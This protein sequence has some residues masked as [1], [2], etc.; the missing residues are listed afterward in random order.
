MRQFLKAVAGTL[1]Q[2]RRLARDGKAAA[3]VEFAGLLPFML[4]LYVGGV[5]VALGVSADRKVTLTSRTVADLASRQTNI[6]DP[7]MTN[8]LGASSAV[9]APFDATKV[10]VIVSN[11]YINNQGVAHVCWSNALNT[12][13][14]TVGS[15]VTLPA[16]LVNK[17]TALMW[18]EASYAYAPT[19]GYYMTG[20]MTLYDNIYM[21]PRMSSTVTRNSA[22]GSC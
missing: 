4:L 11:V 21:A 8:I 10:S 15:T 14:R 6:D 12:T 18:G 5:E 19:L 1:H 22:S 7:T 17:N 2:W 3:V 16:A 13:A 20:T 9:I